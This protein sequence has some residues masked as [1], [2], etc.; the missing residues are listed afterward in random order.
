[1]ELNAP[2]SLPHLRNADALRVFAQRLARLMYLRRVCE[3]DHPVL[4]VENELIE[5]AK[6]KLQEYIFVN[7]PANQT[8]MYGILIQSWIKSI[9]LERAVSSDEDD[10]VKERVME[11]IMAEDLSKLVPFVH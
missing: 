9:A 2:K 3:P 7:V 6:S 10:S 1:M 11:A 8:K 5:M 4:S